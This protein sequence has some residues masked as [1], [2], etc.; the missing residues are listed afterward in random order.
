[1]N[2]KKEANIASP[3]SMIVIYEKTPGP[4]GL[5]AVGFFDGHAQFLSAEDWAR[6]AKKSGL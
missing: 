4:D 2:G 5:R 6:Y 3:Q 1:L